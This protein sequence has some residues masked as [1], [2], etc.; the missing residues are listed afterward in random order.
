MVI[1]DRLSKSL[2]GLSLPQQIYSYLDFSRSE[3]WFGL[4]SS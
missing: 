3:T 1:A 2:V 4:I